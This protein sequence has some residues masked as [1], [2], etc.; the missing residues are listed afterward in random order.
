LRS[1]VRFLGVVLLLHFS[2]CYFISIIKIPK[3]LRIQIL[4]HIS[5]LNATSENLAY[6]LKKENQGPS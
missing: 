2:R 1:E 3:I 5:F 4:R 6:I